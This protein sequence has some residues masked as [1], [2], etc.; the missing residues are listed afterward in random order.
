M[1]AVALASVISSAAVG[2]TGAGVAFYSAHRTAKTAREGRAE[3]RSA[4]GYLKVLS[5]A[6]QEAQWHD[7]HVHNLS[8]DREEL[9][10]GEVKMIRFPEPAGTDRSTAAALIAAFASSTV[11]SSHT[12]WR[13]AADA[14]GKKIQEIGIDMN[15]EDDPEANVP[16]EWMKE[17]TDDLQP[18]ERAARQVLAEAVAYEL[19]HRKPMRRWRLAGRMTLRKPGQ[20]IGSPPAPPPSVTT[21]QP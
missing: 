21:V 18:K 10:W 3:Q 13:E 8:L 4:D 2:L 16:G 9:R 6:E 15:L 19:G 11:R 5:L 17:L 14:L 1:D 7:S 12:A 20:R